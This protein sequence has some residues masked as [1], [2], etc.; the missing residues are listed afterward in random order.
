VQGS[1]R[2][3]TAL[4]NHNFQYGVMYVGTATRDGHG[5]VHEHHD[6]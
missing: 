1:V 3:V 2:H 6:R 4:P 5:V